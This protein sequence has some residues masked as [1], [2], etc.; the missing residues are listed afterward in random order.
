[1]SCTGERDE[2]HGVIPLPAS[3]RVIAPVGGTRQAA[4]AGAISASRAH[5]ALRRMAASGGGSPRLLL[6]GLLLGSLLL[7]AAALPSSPVLKGR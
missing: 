5:R 2:N 6:V 4:T 1:M 7:Q 3:R